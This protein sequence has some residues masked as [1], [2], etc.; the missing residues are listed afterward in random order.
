MG[1]ISPEDLGRTLTH[2]HIYFD[3]PWAFVPPPNKNIEKYISEKLSLSNVGLIKQYPYGHLENFHMMGD[4]VKEAVVFDLKLYKEWGGGSIVENTPHGSHGSHEF[5]RNISIE[6]N[7][8]VVQGT[9]HYRQIVQSESTLQM[10]V[11]QMVNLYTN[12]ILVGNEFDAFPGDPIKC[13]AIGEVASE[14]P[15]TG[16]ENIF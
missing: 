8:H 4:E 12:D 7:V 3:G 16:R 5:A 14:W 13:G 1:E 9:G 2:E 15:I 6:T 11:E 10:T